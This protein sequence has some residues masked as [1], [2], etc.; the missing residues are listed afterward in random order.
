MRSPTIPDIMQTIPLSTVASFARG[1]V[2][3][4]ETENGLR[5]ERFDAETLAYYEKIGSARHDRACCSAGVT[6]AFRTDSRQLALSLDLTT[7][8]RD[9]SFADVCVDGAFIASAGAADAPAF[10]ELQTALPGARGAMRTVSVHLPHCRQ[11]IV[12]AMALDDGARCEADEARP[13]LLAFGD[14]I[15]QGMNAH[16]PA[17]AYATVMARTLDM[18]LLNLGVGGHVFDVEGLCAPPHPA[19]DLITVAYGINDWN[20]SC[21]IASARPWL[22]RLREWYPEAPVFVFEP[23]WAGK[24]GMDVSPKPNSAGRT[25]ADARRELGGIVDEFPG[26]VRVGSDRLMPAVAAFLSD[27][28]HPNDAGHAVYGLNAANAIREA[29]R[30]RA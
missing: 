9:Y 19:P 27:G 24:E 14:S 8:V 6:L 10:I 26:I 23:I 25:L 30:R 1:I 12:R 22:G 5:F 28:L 2:N 13:L 15:T 3:A 17:L 29:L 16:H 18:S 21:D 7:Q 11:A 4:V 20:R